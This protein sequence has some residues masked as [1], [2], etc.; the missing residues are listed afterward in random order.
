VRHGFADLFRR[1]TYE[2][3]P[4]IGSDANHVTAFARQFKDQRLVIATG[5]HFAP[6]SD[7]GRQWP[8]HWNAALD[9]GPGIYE[10]ILD[11]APGRHA[12][13]A[14]IARL[15]RMLPVNVLCRIKRHV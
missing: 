9:L 4:V 2:P 11:S 1:G 10:S 6:L 3:V 8:D 14:E 5:R 12:G 13:Q 15:F 7:Y